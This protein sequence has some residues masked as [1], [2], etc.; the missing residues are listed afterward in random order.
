MP[1]PHTLR[2]RKKV[3]DYI[4][5]TGTTVLATA[6]RFMIPRS[7]IFDWLKKLKKD[8]GLAPATGYQKGHSHKITDL[9]GFEKFVQENPDLTLEE[10]AQKIGNVSDTT[11][12]RMLK[13]LGY[14]Q[15]KRLSII[16]RETNKSGKHIWQKS[17]R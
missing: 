16:Q 8:N 7:T 14:S 9:V 12:G 2:F 1:A 13:K 6:E 3:I 5:K 17:S 15:K 4:A 10:M 11:V